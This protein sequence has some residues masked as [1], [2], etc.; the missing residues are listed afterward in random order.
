MSDFFQF[1][2]ELY[3]FMTLLGLLIGEAGYH[4]ERLRLGFLTAVVGMLGAFMQLVLQKVYGLRPIPGHIVSFDGVAFYF[5]LFFLAL[6]GLSLVLFRYSPRFQASVESE[7]YVFILG[8]TLGGMVLSAST[9]LGVFLIALVLLVL[10]LVFLASADRGSRLG[11]EGAFKFFTRGLWA[12]LAL[13][14]AI[15]IV[16]QEYSTLSLQAL[17]QMQEQ[18][19]LTPSAGLFLFGLV[20]LSFAFLTGAFPA[21]VQTPDLFQSV[22]GFSLPLVVY[23]ARAAGLL[24]LIRVGFPFF[25]ELL[26]DGPRH[27]FHRQENWRPWFEAVALCGALMGAL[28]AFRQK[29]FMRSLG[30]LSVADFSYLLFALCAG[31][32]EG[33]RQVSFSLFLQALTFSGVCYVLAQLRADIR[34]DDWQG[35]RERLKGRVVERVVLIVLLASWMGLPPL[36]AFFVK[37]KILYLTL[38]DHHM[39]LIMGGLV[40]VALSWVVLGKMMLALCAGGARE[41]LGGAQVGRVSDRSGWAFAIPV[42][43]LGALTQPILHW[44]ERT[45]HFILW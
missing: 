25:G 26:T 16:Y 41:V 2:P 36:P 17:Y 3:I 42:I 31:G 44:M 22:P 10:C 15:A 45:F 19:P 40:S 20:F 21:V 34:G 37:F 32:I 38:L 23:V 39:L 5:R 4:G 35:L 7:I 12:F 30:Y 14:I 1:L 43:I 27:L 9:H 18:S 13:M 29:S 33:I 28:L 11:T 8:A 24:L 6:G